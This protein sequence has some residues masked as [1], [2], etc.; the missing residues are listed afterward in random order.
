MNSSTKKEETMANQE[1][2]R[3]VLEDLIKQRSLLQYRIGEIEAAVTALKR[4]MPDEPVVEKRIAPAQTVMNGMPGKYTG[5]GVRAAILRMLAEDAVAPMRTVEMAHALLKG[6]V[7]TT[8]KK[9]RANVAAIVSDMYKRR[10][11]LTPGEAGGWTITE[12]GKNAWIEI[13]SAP[14]LRHSSSI[15]AAQPSLQ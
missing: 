8:G 10:G 14:N 13:K 5:M 11:E 7:S 3:A 9:F 15:F 1:Q 6:G 2:Y 4:L 12:K